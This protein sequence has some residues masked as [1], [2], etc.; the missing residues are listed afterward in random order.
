MAEL[1]DAS[2]VSA[3]DYFNCAV[4]AEGKVPCWGLGRREFNLRRWWR[5]RDST[6]VERTGR[7]RGFRL[8][9]S[10]GSSRCGVGGANSFAV[11]SATDD[12]EARS[13]GAG[14]GLADADVGPSVHLRGT[15]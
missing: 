11:R 5:S 12:S 3:G 7:G 10:G 13:C 14:P 4:R 8:C 2:L 9:D 1:N 15:R 6:Q